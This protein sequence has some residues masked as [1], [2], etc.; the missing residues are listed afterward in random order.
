MPPRRLFP[1]LLITL[2][3]GYAMPGMTRSADGPD[4]GPGG[5]VCG[6][7][8]TLISTV[9][10]HAETSPLDGRVADIEAIVIGAFQQQDGLAGLFVQQSEPQ[11]DT[12]PQTSEGLFV[13]TDLTAQPGDRIRVRGTV[14]ELK[15]LTEL[16]PVTSLAVCSSGNALPAPS[17]LHLPLA[18]LAAL[19]ALE[20]MRVVLPQALTITDTWALGEFGEL[21]VSSRRLAQATQLHAPGPQAA[22]LSHANT[23]DRLLVDDGRNSHNA[24]VSWRGQ[25]DAAAFSALNPIRSGQ[26]ISGLQGVMHHAFGRYRLQPTAAFT[27]DETGNPRSARPVSVGRQS[28][29]GQLKVASFNVLN[30][31]STLAGPQPACGPQRDET[32]RG[33]DTTGEQARQRDK[34]VAAIGAID[35]AIVGLLELE[36]N[37][38]QSLLDLVDGLNQA[39]GRQLYAYVASGTL[40]GDVIKVGLI[41]KPEA[42]T[43]LGEFAVLDSSVDPRFDDR[44]SRPALAQSFR[45]NQG[46]DMLTVVV[47]HL[48]SKSCS[49]ASG[50]NADQ[51]DGQGCFNRARTLAA[52][53]LADWVLADSTGTGASAVLVVGDFNSYR[54]ED[55]VRAMQDR[56]L[57]DLLAQFSGGGQDE[58]YTYIYEGLAGTLDYTFGSPG[59]IPRVTGATVWHINADEATVLDYNDL[60]GKPEEYHDSGPF[61]SSDHDPVIVGL[62]PDRALFAVMEQAVPAARQSTLSRLILWGVLALALGLV[63]AGWRLRHSR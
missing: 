45:G 39:A 10:G 3:A 60:P 22:L 28:S 57:V 52:S 48:K 19:E 15:G 5:F 61:R 9:Q 43:P 13:H 23:L 17:V 40:G 50:A 29:G 16:N 7:Q 34:L 35:A 46:G 36:N 4:P 20:N 8:A 44:L 63:Y 1:V 21:V 18:S 53:A 55:P 2:G 49:G 41:F 27:I 47:T 33:A 31:F 14:A 6:Q 58:D 32:C 42:V 59:L 11:Q 38:E 30:Y 37:P 26:R 62:M 24:P 51:G 25:D 54:M 12:D 56:G